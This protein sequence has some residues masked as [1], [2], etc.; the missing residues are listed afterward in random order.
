MAFLQNKLDE[1]EKYINELDKKAKEKE[2]LEIVCF[3]IMINIFL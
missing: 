2:N 3:F 1:K